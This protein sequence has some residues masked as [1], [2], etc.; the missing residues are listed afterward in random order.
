[1]LADSCWL[2]KIATDLHILAHVNT[3]CPD[4]GYPE[5]VI[6]VLEKILDSCEFHILA[7][8]NTECPDD[9]YPKLVICVLEMIL[10]S[11]EYIPVANVTMNCM[12]L[13]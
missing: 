2:R 1:M 8:V 11:C 5:L 3:E 7:H 9:G 10:D 13:L 4:D 12:I 6:C